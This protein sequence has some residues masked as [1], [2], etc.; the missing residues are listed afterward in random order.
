MSGTAAY[1][2]GAPHRD[3]AANPQDPAQQP[4]DEEQT[5][6]GD[7]S[8]RGVLADEDDG[9]QRLLRG[10]EIRMDM[11]GAV[12]ALLQRSLLRP[13][14][15]FHGAAQA[16]LTDI[17]VSQLRLLEHFVTLRAVFCMAQVRPPSSR[18][19]REFECC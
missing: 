19:H 1:L 11:G 7:P 14:V 4:R 6:W 8:C 10:K 9:W 13:I 18:S 3:I 15:E 12:R 17:F 5:A 16:A 2:V